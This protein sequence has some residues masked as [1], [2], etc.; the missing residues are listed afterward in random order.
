MYVLH[1]YAHDPTLI[2]SQSLVILHTTNLKLQR[3]IHNWYG[4]INR[5]INVNN[6]DILGGSRKICIY[7]SFHRPDDDY[8]YY[9][10]VFTRQTQCCFFS[11]P[12]F[13]LSRYSLLYPP[14]NDNINQTLSFH[15]FGS[16]ITHSKFVLY[17]VI[18]CLILRFFSF[19]S[20]ISLTIEFI[21]L[22]PTYRIINRITCPLLGDQ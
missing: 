11:P 10:R 14:I 7:S 16:P 12:L 3:P 15:H 4:L 22:R 17:R 1:K 13:S 2:L 5:V 6:G 20:L 21:K 19:F 18:I 9:S 8:S